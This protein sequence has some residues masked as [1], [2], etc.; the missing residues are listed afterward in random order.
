MQDIEIHS[1]YFVEYNLDEIKKT[2]EYGT[3]VIFMVIRSLFL[4]S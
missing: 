3:L 4:P 1:H 2:I